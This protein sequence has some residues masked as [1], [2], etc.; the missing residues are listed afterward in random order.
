MAMCRI[1]RAKLL[2]SA[3]AAVVAA[4]GATP[5]LAQIEEII[6]TA[7]KKQETLQSAPIAVSAFTQAT[8][9]EA[10]LSSIRELARLAPTL[11]FQESFGRR[12]DRPALRGQTT[13]GTPDFGVESGVAIFIDGVYVSGDASAFGLNDLERVEI[14]RGPQSALY[15]RNTYAGAI[16]F[17]T[18]RPTDEYRGGGSLRF[19]QHGEREATAR[20]SGPLVPGK[21][22]FTLN[23]R[24]YNYD[25]EYTNTVTGEKVGSEETLS[26]AGSLAYE[27]DPFRATLRLSHAHDKDGHIPLYM[28]GFADGVLNCAPNARGVFTYY[29]GVIPPVGST[30]SFPDPNSVS[31]N[32]PTLITPGMD[33]EQTNAIFLAEANLGFATLRSATGYRD[34]SRETSSDSDGTA[35]VTTAIFN[36]L[37]K[38][39]DWSQ[40]FRLSSDPARDFRWEVGA[41]YFSQDVNTYNLRTGAFDSR[42]ET[43]NS[44]VFGL[45]GYQFTPQLGGTAELRYASERKELF[46]PIANPQLAAII[47]GSGEE[48]FDSWNPRFLLDYQLTDELMVYGTVARGNKPGG[49]NNELAQ[50]LDALGR[51]PG[52]ASFREETSWSYELGVKASWLSDRL[53]TN[54]ATYY[55]DIQNLQLTTNVAN[56]APFIPG[57]TPFTSVSAIYNVDGAKNLGVEFEFTASLF[58]GLTV[59]GG[60]AYVNSELEGIVPEQVAFNGT[61]SVDGKRMPRTPEWKYSVN[62]TYRTQVA[63]GMDWFIR[64]DLSYEGSRYIQIHNLAE[65]GSATIVNLRTGIDGD[66][67]TVTLFG[68]NITDE[69]AIV[70][71]LRFV[72]FRAPPN[73]GFLTTLRRGSQWGV[74]VSV[75]F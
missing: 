2:M 9:R 57:I 19:A 65:T 23:G 12:D 27:S 38:S 37:Q 59:G 4:A 32:T 63:A 5:A 25:G 30:R 74:E 47:A 21:V 52:I 66:G 69:D 61:G 71:A 1:Y 11:S 14:I 53:V 45:L 33:R 7:R 29:C 6:V 15:G 75:D 56:T 18:R 17:I 28:F 8:I 60:V 62:G 26:A 54:I 55:T 20:V 16:N 41:F 24:G 40:E 22:F 43:E 3:A 42:R 51:R 36:T 44:A 39:E 72:D 13:I 49:I 58:E 10:G 48:T 31:L 35:V 46:L 73:R 68:K 70:D 34:E 50:A 67:Y 64:G